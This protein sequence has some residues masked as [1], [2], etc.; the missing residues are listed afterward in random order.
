MDRDEALRLL[1]E[2]Y[3]CALRLR[4]AGLSHLIAGRLEIPPEAVTP[5][6]HLAEAKLSRLLTAGRRTAGEQ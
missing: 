6:L 5:L 4:D 2:S 3:E 1:P